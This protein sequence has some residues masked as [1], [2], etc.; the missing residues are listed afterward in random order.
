MGLGAGKVSSWQPE[1]IWIE[2]E[3]TV[4]DRTWACC[5]SLVYLLGASG[6]S[7]A[8]L[9]YTLEGHSKVHFCPP[10][11]NSGQCSLFRVAGNDN[12]V[13]GK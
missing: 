1:G 7:Q 5:H 4:A 12:F 11:M 3:V 6:E 10:P 9:R 2:M 8:E 13:K